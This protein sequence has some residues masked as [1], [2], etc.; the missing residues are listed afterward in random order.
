MMSGARVATP[1]I[2]RGGGP[3]GHGRVL[4]VEDVPEDR[5][6]VERILREACFEPVGTDQPDDLVNSVEQWNPRAIIL[7]AD[8][9]RGFTACHRLKKDKVLRRIPLVLVSGRAGPDVIRKHRLLP[10]RA[11]HYLGKPV[12][13]EELQRVLAELLPED[14]REPAREITVSEAPDRTLVGGGL[15]T[16][17][18]TYVEE[19]VSSLKSRLNAKVQALEQ[20]LAQERARLDATLRALA[21]HQRAE[22]EILS[23]ERLEAAREDGRREA[24]EEARVQLE[25]LRSRV[26][27]LEAALEAS[28]AHAEALRAEIAQ[29]QVLFER[30][31]AG[32]KESIATADEEKQA[33]EASLT[34][35]ENEVDSLRAERDTLKAAL[36]GLPALQESAARCELLEEELGR[37]RAEK[38]DLEARVEALTTEVGSL[39]EDAAEVATLQAANQALREQLQKA[40]DGLA[41]AEEARKVAEE[42]LA[43]MRS[44]QEEMREM[45]RRLKS[46]LDSGVDG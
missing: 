9:P 18:V 20:Q 34:A 2:A 25:A 38:D 22:R 43:A 15:E 8:M 45:F 46:V 39:K 13:R 44:E 24:R 41:A 26:A 35:L 33:M 1:K 11:D 6:H 4:V 5:E 16:A 30:L 40:R 17:V 10:T 28:R 7:S 36:R 42:A 27:E 23:R 19:E 14:F 37:L 3:A 31:E 21:E 29:N 12:D 32:Y